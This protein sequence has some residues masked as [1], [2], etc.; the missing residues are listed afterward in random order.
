[1][2]DLTYRISPE[3]RQ[4]RLASFARRL[5]SAVAFMVGCGLVNVIFFD[6]DSVPAFFGCL[7]GAF[8]ALGALEP[9]K[10]YFSAPYQRLDLDPAGLTWHDGPTRRT[11]LWEDLADCDVPDATE[12]VLSLRSRHGGSLEIPGDFENFP[13]L[14]EEVRRRKP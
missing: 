10:R 4:R 2:V 6:G 14:V 12:P 9:L 13:T 8:M 7:F 5:L 3:M 11:M 1:M